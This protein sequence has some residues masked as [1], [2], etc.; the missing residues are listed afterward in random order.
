[1]GQENDQFLEDPEDG[2]NRVG[3]LDLLE[4]GDSTRVKASGALLSMIK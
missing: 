2:C 1:M 3:W 4:G